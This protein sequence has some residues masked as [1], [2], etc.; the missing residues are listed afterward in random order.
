MIYK[1]LNFYLVTYEYMEIWK[2]LSSIA[3]I[4]K[5]LYLFLSYKIV[6]FCKA[7]SS[8]NS[9]CCNAAIPILHTITCSYINTYFYFIKPMLDNSF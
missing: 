7:Y 1:N 5:I 9:L 3:I 2:P 6:T 8:I 4:S